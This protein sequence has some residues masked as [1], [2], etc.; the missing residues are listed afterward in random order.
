MRKSTLKLPAWGYR[1][2]LQNLRKRENSSGTSLCCKT[3]LCVRLILHYTYIRIYILVESL[4]LLWFKY[5]KMIGFSIFSF[6]DCSVF[7]LSQSRYNHK[8]LLH[9]QI[10]LSN[11]LKMCVIF[12]LQQQKFFPTKLRKKKFSNT[13]SSSIVVQITPLCPSQSHTDVF[14][15]FSK[16]SCS[17]QLSSQ[18]KVRFLLT[19]KTFSSF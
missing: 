4:K 1:T 6:I 18:K 8:N 9:L 7:L 12:L 14:H 5:L 15:I 3:A 11:I 10:V 16:M 17:V 2:P 13:P 19:E